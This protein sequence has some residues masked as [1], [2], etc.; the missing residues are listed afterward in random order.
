MIRRLVVLVA[1]G[2]GFVGCSSGDRVVVSAASSLTEV[3]GALEDA[4]EDAEPSVDIVLNLGGSG[5]LREQILAG[6]PADVF[7]PA[8]W[9]QMEAVADESIGPPVAFA[10]NTMVI[11]T[12]VGNPAGI[13]DVGD[14]ADPDPFLGACAPSVPCGALASE[15]FEAA[16]VDPQ[17]DTEE[18]SVRALLTK[19]E[20]GDLD[21]GIVYA[22]D[23][24]VADVD[25]V[26]IPESSNAV[27]QYPI[28]LLSDEPG[29]SGFVSFVLSEAGQQILADH[30]FGG[31]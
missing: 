3:F 15:V 19:V 23:V 31:P 26:A 9:D 22:T 12:T 7:A 5:A 16:G 6:A 29:A 17:L 25:A 10:S 30:G 18:A 8:S 21:A 24:L 13:T 11:A 14:F 28:A 1:L 4:Y 20:S 2:L 27:T